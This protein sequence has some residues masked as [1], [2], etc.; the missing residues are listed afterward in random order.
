[1]KKI[2]VAILILVLLGGGAYGGYAWWSGNLPSAGDDAQTE[3]TVERLPPEFEL[4]M[5]NA[6]AAIEEAETLLLEL[7]FESGIGSK[8]PGVVPQKVLVE[9]QLTEGKVG[10]ELRFNLAQQWEI[11]ATYLPQ[12]IP[13]GE[14]EG[15]RD[16]LQDDIM[17]QLR[18]TEGTLY[19]R[20][21]ALLGE[22]WYHY[23]VEELAEDIGGYVA[24]MFGGG[25]LAESIEQLDGFVEE[26][27]VPLSTP[28]S[29]PDAQNQEPEEMNDDSL[30]QLLSSFNNVTYQGEET[31]DTLEVYR[32]QAELNTG[33]GQ[34]LISSLDEAE[35]IVSFELDDTVNSFPSVSVDMWFDQ[36]TGQLVKFSTISQEEPLW[37]TTGLIHY[38]QLLD[39]ELP[40]QSVNLRDIDLTNPV[41]GTLLEQYFKIAK[42]LETTA[43]DPEALARDE[44]RI[45]EMNA[46]SEAIV[47]YAE[48]QLS[49]GNVDYLQYPPVDRDHK[50]E[51]YLVPDYIVELPEP[52]SPEFNYRYNADEE[53]REYALVTWLE[54]TDS[55]YV[56]GEY[57]PD[58]H[59][60]LV[61]SMQGESPF[62]YSAYEGREIQDVFYDLDVRTQE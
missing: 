45:L 25:M 11:L 46:L 54:T 28:L 17:I 6:Q 40:D 19:L 27:W 38:P 37:Q 22:S 41:S 60:A 26:E 16:L 3:E 49:E 55:P 32:F 21:P 50:L 10:F 20:V 24:G 4:L 23:L 36:I 51:P 5:Q 58:S 53:G 13:A 33:P 8:E 15:L 30:E 7:E 29:S 57:H 14:L 47:N 43:V 35:G 31:L 2:L 12:G 62:D 56:L 1:M 34:E 42:A 18:A 44:Q 48:D 61:E 9:M 52:P 39:V 59:E